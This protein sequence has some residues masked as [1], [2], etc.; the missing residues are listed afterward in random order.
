MSN[1]PQPSGF[2]LRAVLEAFGNLQ[3]S[4]SSRNR[5]PTRTQYDR[6]DRVFD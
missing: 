6:I 4:W 2:L 5:K 1:D 3:G